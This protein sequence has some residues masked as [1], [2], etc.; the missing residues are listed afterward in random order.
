M[1]FKIFLRVDLK[2][3]TLLAFCFVFVSFWT[4]VLCFTC[5]I[6][7]WQSLS[8]G[9]A[10]LSDCF[11]RLSPT[12]C[13]LFQALSIEMCFTAE[14]LQRKHDLTWLDFIAQLTEHDD[15]ITPLLRGASHL[16]FV[17][18]PAPARAGPDCHPR[19]LPPKTIATQN[20]CHL[21]QLPSGP[22]PPRIMRFTNHIQAIMFNSKYYVAACTE[23]LA[24]RRWST[25]VQTR[26]FIFGALGYL[27]LGSLLEGLR[28]LM[29]YKLALYVL[30][31]I[32]EQVVPNHKHNTL[33]WIPSTLG[34]QTVTRDERKR[35]RWSFRWDTASWC[36]KNTCEK[37]YSN[38]FFL[39]SLMIT[40]G[41]IQVSIRLKAEVRWVPWGSFVDFHWSISL[42]YTWNIL[43]T[44]KL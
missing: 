16:G 41:Q 39:R 15:V 36:A 12:L 30:D 7:T 28:R 31:T 40:K 24:A 32:T 8:V 19:Q 17:L 13:C 29:L 23:V 14:Y 22:L 42:A 44:C 33:F 11:S 10:W 43:L 35:Q 6:E 26:I 1:I 2:L 20:I 25:Y 37:R 18:G 4:H 38:C 34:T 27:K 21:G 5:N 9:W 3:N